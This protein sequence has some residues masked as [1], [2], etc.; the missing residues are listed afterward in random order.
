M[1][2]QFDTISNVLFGMTILVLIAYSL[3][4][5]RCRKDFKRRRFSRCT[6]PNQAPKQQ[7][8]RQIRKP[9][10]V[11]AEVLRLLAM[12]RGHAGCRTVAA[13]F[14]ARFAFRGES[15]S[16]TYVAEL[17]KKSRYE[18]LQLRKIL[19]QPPRTGKPNQTWVLD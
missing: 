8:A 15:V 19:R 18:I 9:G 10:W 12:T 11:K 13:M 4:S 6:R 1:P 14:N 7:R 16:K 5:L 3:K 2:I 17:R